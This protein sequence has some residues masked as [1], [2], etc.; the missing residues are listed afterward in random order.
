MTAQFDLSASLEDYMETIFHIIEEKQ[1]ARA[2]E[3]AEQLKVSRASVTEALKALRKKRL[4]HYATYEVITLTDMGRE[5]ALDIVRRHRVL[6]DFFMK[7]LAV[8]EPLAEKGAC[9]IEHT[10]PPEIIERLIAFVKFLENS[11]PDA[12][13][14]LDDFARQV[15]SR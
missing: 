9:R 6:K 14:L 12:S 8:K 7:V 2:K 13:R 11:G 10:A 4:I 1:V 5:V 15:G 3:I